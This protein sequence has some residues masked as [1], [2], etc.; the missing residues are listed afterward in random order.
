[1]AH[2]FG[3]MLY[4]ITFR[5]RG[6]RE[7][8]TFESTP[9]PQD[10]S[11]VRVFV[12]YL[13]ARHRR[14]TRLGQLDNGVY[15]D[16]RALRVESYTADPNACRVSGI[17]DVGEA[18]AGDK[19]HDFDKPTDNAV[20]T[21]L[22]NQGFL[23][24]LYFQARFL[25]GANRGLAL[26]GTRGQTSLKGYLH[27]DLTKHLGA[28]TIDKVS[29]NMVPVHDARALEQFSK[30]GKL[31]QVVIRFDGKSKQSREAVKSYNVGGTVFDPETDVVEM[32]WKRDGGFPK[33]VLNKVLDIARSR[34]KVGEVVKGADATRSD[35]VSIVMERGGRSQKFS[36]NSPDGSQLRYDITEDVKLDDNG[37]PTRE[38][39]D[40]AAN[41]ILDDSDLL[42]LVK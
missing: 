4:A 22:R 1:M 18:A 10:T 9:N 38:S 26:L 16:D 6:T 2:R 25:K 40:E 30:S 33:A 23:V 32:T 14:L 5:N 7:N 41:R 29:H 12:N 13:N 39:L 11:G 15:D 37:R 42:S 35:D 8:W 19:L 28:S 21:T 20:L 3:L 36:M 17:I 34:A 24:P 31:K 27:D